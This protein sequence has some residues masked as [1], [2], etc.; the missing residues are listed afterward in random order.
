[1]TGQLPQYPPRMIVG[2]EIVPVMERIITRVMTTIDDIVNKTDPSTATFDAV[3]TPY[4]TANNFI[5]DEIGVIFM[6]Q[7]AAPDKSTQEEVAKAIRLWSDAHSSLLARK[8]YFVLLR[9]I[10]FKHEHLEPESRLLLDEMLLDCEE[11]G[12]GQ[13]SD[14]EMSQYLQTGAEI[15]EL[16]IKFQHN[17]AYDN[18]G[19]WFKEADLEGVPAEMIAKWETEQN[20]SGSQR[21]FVPFA[22]GGTLALVTHAKAAEVRRAIFLGDHNN[23]SENDL[24]LKKIVLRR[25]KQA[26]RLGHKS[27]AAMRA[28]RRLLK[29][30]EAIRDFLEN[31]RPDLIN[32]GKAEI[33]TLS[34]CA[35]Q[36]DLEATKD[37]NGVLPAWD[38]AYYGK[39]LEK[40]L[41]ID[42]VRISEYFPLDH[43]AEAMLAVFESLLGL[44][45]E[46]I[47][48][49]ELGAEYF[50]HNSVRAFAVWEE[51]HTAFIGYLFFDLLW[52][53]NKYRGNQNV[54]HQC[55]YERSDGSRRCPST[56]LMCSFP[57]A[58]AG[59]P[60]LLKHREVVTLFHELG[61]GIHNLV[62][63]TKYVRFHG[64]NLPP[65][66]GEM[67]SIFLE[68]Y[69]WMEEVLRRLSRHYTNLEPSYLEDWRDRNPDTPVPPREIP[70]ELVQPLIRNRYMNRASYHLKQLAISLFDL[71]IHGV[72]TSVEAE[73]LNLRDLFYSLREDCEGV[74]FGDLRHTGSWHGTIPHLTGGYDVGYYSYLVCTAFAQDIFQ[75]AFAK[76]PWNRNMWERFRFEVLQ[77]GGGHPD[78]MK[79]LEGFLGR[80]LDSSIFIKTMKSSIN[81]GQD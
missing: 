44:Y 31:L 47:T 10:Q 55:G 42:H 41:D 78:M 28:Q 57:T 69:C 32:L 80:P 58:S 46:E 59:R 37:K 77:P 75:T 22:N 45:F 68:N 81:A 15:N 56:I 73:A 14:G 34:R 48:Q 49:V 6:L 70:S 30:S 38:Q 8:D 5:Q 67:P 35:E 76:D 27:H 3:V 13:M 25:Q 71:E 54:T 74:S 43:T 39:L 26:N 36:D 17:M 4:A 63:K 66:F 53:E 19:L 40:Q 60:V 24:L 72:G 50:W 61:H 20:D 23:L 16:V 52:R 51:D 21:T 62:S 29:S 64:T 2:D 7:Y 11:C 18:N 33:E 1:M 12:L 9:A 65:D 79:M